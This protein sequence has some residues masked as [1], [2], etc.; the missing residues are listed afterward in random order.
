MPLHDWTRVDRREFGGFAQCWRAFLAGAL[1]R[2]GLPPGYYAIGDHSTPV[3]PSDRT[4]ADWL[5]PAEPDHVVGQG[6]AVV[7]LPTDTAPI[8][9]K[10]L[11]VRN[12]VVIRQ[13]DR[14]VVA[15]IELLTASAKRRVAEWTD[16]VT[17]SALHLRNGVGVVVIDPFPP[18]RHAPAGFHPAFWNALTRRTAA[19]QPAGKPLTVA[20]YARD[21]DGLATAYVSPLAAGDPLPDPVLFLHPGLPVR[22]PLAAAYAEAWRG[23]PQPLRRELEAGLP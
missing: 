2:G 20:S 23:H 11:V 5:D 17:K 19:P 6:V 16:L 22:V 21:A 14:R 3:F 13:D 18:G 15:V 9:P 10:G 8:R 12:Q 4:V 7:G 1:N